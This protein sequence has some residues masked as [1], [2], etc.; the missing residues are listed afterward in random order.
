MRL[1]LPLAVPRAEL[2]DAFGERLRLALREVPPEHAD[3]RGPLQ[4]REVER[5]LRDLAGGEAHY[6]QPAAP[7]ERAERRLAVRPAHRIVH[8]VHAALLGDRLDALAQVF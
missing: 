2:A 7:G 8:D 4:Q 1:E 3:D 6:Q 5:Q